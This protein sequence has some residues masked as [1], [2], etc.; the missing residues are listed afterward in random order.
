MLRIKVCIIPHKLVLQNMKTI[1]M[2]TAKTSLCVYLL[3]GC[4]SYTLSQL[5]KKV[6]LDLIQETSTLSLGLDHTYKKAVCEET[7]QKGE[8]Q[9]S[10]KLN[11]LV[12][13]KTNWTNL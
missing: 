5:Y 9:L 13:I 1:K 7:V 2:K 8:Q 11:V 4:V 10:L 6:A 3:S 12:S